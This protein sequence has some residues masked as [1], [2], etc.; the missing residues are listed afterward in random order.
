MLLWRAII[1]LIWI[2]IILLITLYGQIW[3]FLLMVLSFITVGIVEYNDLFKLRGKVPNIY[4][5]IF[6]SLIIPVLMFFYS[7]SISLYIFITIF[8]VSL[9]WGILRGK[10]GGYIVSTSATLN[11]IL[12]VGYLL[13]HL[14]LLRKMVYGEWIVTILFGAVWGL[15]VVSYLFGSKFGRRVLAP[16]ISPK[17]S[18]EGAISGFIAGTTIFTVGSIYLPGIDIKSIFLRILV[19]MFVSVVAILGD[20]VESAMKRDAKV[21]DSG[22]ILPGHGGILDRFDSLIFAAPT[23]YYILI[24]FKWLGF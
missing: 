14:V 16:A 3:H 13:G 20:L 1:A 5:A 9:V 4:V 23:L 21:K 22:N 2:P 17:K 19:G 24:L 15:D 12:Y 18:F 8:L 7:P 11:G 10:V 6:G